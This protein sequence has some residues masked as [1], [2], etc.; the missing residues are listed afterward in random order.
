MVMALEHFHNTSMDKS[1]T[2]APTT[3]W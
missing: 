1:S 2:C 3:L